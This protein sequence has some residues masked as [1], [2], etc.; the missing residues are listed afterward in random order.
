ME[1]EGFLFQFCEV[2]SIGKN[3]QENSTFIDD[4]FKN[5]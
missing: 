4:N 5:K 1:V 2:T 3:T